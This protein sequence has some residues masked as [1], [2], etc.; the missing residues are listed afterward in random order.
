MTKQAVTPNTLRL[1][2]LF[3]VNRKQ[4]PL[5]PSATSTRPIRVPDDIRGIRVSRW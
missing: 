3:K 2:W 4:Q 5:P 1:A